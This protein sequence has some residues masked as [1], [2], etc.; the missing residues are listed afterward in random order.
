M[1]PSEWVW[2][3][4]QGL[5]CDFSCVGERRVHSSRAQPLIPPA[6]TEDLLGSTHKHFLLDPYAALHDSYSWQNSLQ[7]AMWFAPSLYTGKRQRV[8]RVPLLIF[9]I[10]QMPS[11]QCTCPLLYTVC[12]RGCTHTAIHAVLYRANLGVFRCDY[13]FVFNY[14][15]HGTGDWIQG[16]L[17]VSYNFSICLFW[18]KVLLNCSICLASYFTR[19]QISHVL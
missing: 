19:Y 9:Y 14:H 3:H 7:Q 16:G 18:N 4:P 6:S 10:I 11:V 17:L 8:M 1:R 12:N 2:R 15:F 13:I 5:G